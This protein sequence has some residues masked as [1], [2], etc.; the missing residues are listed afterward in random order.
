LV[1]ERPKVGPTEEVE[2]RATHLGA[3]CEQAPPSFS[4]SPAVAQS[5]PT[6]PGSESY[7]RAVG[8]LRSALERCGDSLAHR[9]GKPRPLAASAGAA[10]RAGREKSLRPQ[11]SGRDESFPGE[12]TID[13]SYGE[14]TGNLSNR[15]R[16]TTAGGELQFMT[17]FE[18]MGTRRGIAARPLVFC[19]FGRGGQPCSWVL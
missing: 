12:I 18:V 14:K 19:C 3:R 4:F 7:E 6:T 1:M 17:G 16:G 2:S 5:T 10:S 15:S 9:R 8:A 13:R 11:K